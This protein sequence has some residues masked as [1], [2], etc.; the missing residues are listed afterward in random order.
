MDY[1]FNFHWTVKL[2]YMIF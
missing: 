2:L 1:I